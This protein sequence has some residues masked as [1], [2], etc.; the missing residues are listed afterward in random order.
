VALISL[1]LTAYFLASPQVWE[2]HYIMLLPVIIMAYRERPG[3]WLLAMWLLL[4]LPTPFGF[5]GLQPMIAS[6]HDLRAFALEPAWQPILQHTAKAAPT[7]GL[8]TYWVREILR[9]EPIGAQHS[10]A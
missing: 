4:A 2:H 3:P 9:P 1:W 8:F 7:L 6:N 5:I 10:G